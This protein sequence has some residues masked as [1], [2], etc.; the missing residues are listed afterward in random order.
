MKPVKKTFARLSA[1]KNQQINVLGNTKMDEN[2]S[3]NIQKIPNIAILGFSLESNRQAP[4]SD[5][6]A[7][8]ENL[9][10]N[11]CDIK[12]ELDGDRAGLPV[13]VQGFCSRMDTIGHWTPIPILIAE[14]PPG[15]PVENSFFLSMLRDMR[16]GLL[17][18]A[19][20]DAVYISE[21]GAGLTTEDDDADGAV[22]EMVRTAVGPNIPIVATLDLHGHVTSKMLSSTDVM[23]SFKTNPHVDQFERGF[24]A[25]NIINSMLNGMQ[26]SSALVKVPMISPAVSLLTANGPYA[27]LIDYGQTLLND[28]IINISI[29]AGFAPADAST[30]GMSVLV[31]TK[32]SGKQS[33]ILAQDTANHIAKRAWVERHR[34]KANLIKPQKMIELCKAV[35]ENPNK[36]SIIIADVAD[37]P[38]GGGRGN[39]AFALRALLKA[40]IK[41]AA[42]GMI[43]DPAL[44]KEAHEIG[45]GKSFCAIFNRDEA[46]KFSDKWQAQATILKLIKGSCVG[47]RGL[48][49]GRRLDLGLCALLSVDGVKVVISTA[50]HQLAD[51]IF[52]ERLGIGISSLRILVVKSR[53]HF[54]AG[55]DETHTP[56]EIFE[57]DFP[58]LTSPLIEKLHL[59]NVKRPIF[60]LDGDMEWVV[61]LFED[62]NH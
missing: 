3:T 41:H 23:V 10:L 30:N 13:T 24:E 29:L 32:G 18:E 14:A 5:R 25:A 52:L 55:F 37:N 62:G 40:K 54:R 49:K 27:D 8:V 42:V 44:A 46:T 60:P 53:G 20:I 35:S 16:E 11:S 58:G 31:T 28:N 36:P 48:Y 19:S 26:V 57:V 17:S 51:P 59:K 4:I 61:P 38:G 7:F 34:Y 12:R 21:H 1:Y 39:T 47:R 9:Y 15:G 33:K 50:R 22:F 6:N 2:L 43:I 56:S 45:E